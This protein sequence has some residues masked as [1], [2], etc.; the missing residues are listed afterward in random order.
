MGGDFIVSVSPLNDY[1]GNLMGLFMSLGIS[2]ALKMWKMNLEYRFIQKDLLIKEIH[3]RVKNNLQ[4]ISSL[5]YLQEDYVK[6][7]SYSG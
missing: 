6:E 3:H 1:E 2:L 7:R 4:I 5:L